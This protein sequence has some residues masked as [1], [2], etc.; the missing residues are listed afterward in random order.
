M[1]LVVIIFERPLKAVE[2]QKQMFGKDE[3]IPM[4]VKKCVR[5]FA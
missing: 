5:D 4:R 3:F 1:E 2:A